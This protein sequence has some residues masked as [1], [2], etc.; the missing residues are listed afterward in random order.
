[1]SWKSWGVILT[2]SG[3]LSQAPPATE[4]DLEAAESW[5]HSSVL[6]QKFLLLR[7]IWTVEIHA[8]R[9]DQQQNKRNQSLDLSIFNSI[10]HMHGPLIYTRV[11]VKLPN[12]GCLLTPA[13]RTN[14]NH[15]SL[16]GHTSVRG[17]NINTHRTVFPWQLQRKM[18]SNTQSQ[19][20]NLLWKKKKK[21]LAN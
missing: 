9:V 1:M 6:R 20:K 11:T 3:P 14:T 21:S 8:H 19:E 17:L 18:S 16:P 4:S 13:V 12:N 2:T 10:I 7:R 5:R 15:K